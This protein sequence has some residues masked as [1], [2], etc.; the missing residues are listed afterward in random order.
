VVQEILL[1][2][3]ELQLIILVVAVAVAMQRAHLLPAQ[4]VLA[5]VEM[6]D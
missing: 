4:E 2:L 6:E 3:T 1:L 5:V